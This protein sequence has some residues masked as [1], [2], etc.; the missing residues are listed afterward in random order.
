MY[1]YFFYFFFLFYIFFKQILAAFTSRLKSHKSCWDFASTT[2]S[3][4][5]LRWSFFWVLIHL[6]YFLENKSISKMVLCLVWAA[7]KMEPLTHHLFFYKQQTLWHQTPGPNHPPRPQI[8]FEV[9]NAGVAETLR[10]WRPAGGIVGRGWMQLSLPSTLQAVPTPR[11]G[12][13]CSGRKLQMLAG[14]R[15]EPKSSQR[16]ENNK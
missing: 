11:T 15:A 5:T 8:E 13:P 16:F 6:E 4:L 2:F 12:K 10:T 1:L 3:Q 9:R 14:V 7:N